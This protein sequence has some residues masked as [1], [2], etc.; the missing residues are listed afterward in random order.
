MTAKYDKLKRK[1]ANCGEV[2]AEHKS[3]ML[4]YRE[5]LT[6]ATRKDEA[7]RIE[8]EQCEEESETAYPLTSHESAVLNAYPLYKA[9]DRRFVSTALNFM[10][11]ENLNE[12]QDRVLKIKSNSSVQSKVM[13]PKKVQKI[14]TLMH[15]RV[16]R[17]CDPVEK[18]DR[19]QE[20]Y[21][22]SLISKAL[23]YK[24]KH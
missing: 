12:L 2:L 5:K 20:K 7:L 4:R 16:G 8:C 23:L 6:R 19:M 11:A 13:T 17:I 14:Y 9:C 3:K 18:L 1:M 24:K 10:Y 22:R 15:E 21:M